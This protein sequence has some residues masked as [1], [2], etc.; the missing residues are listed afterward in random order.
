MGSSYLLAQMAAAQVP[1]ALGTGSMG[2]AILVPPLNWCPSYPHPQQYA[3]V[4]SDTE[5]LVIMVMVIQI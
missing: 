1:V 3:T 5:R 4:S 2:P